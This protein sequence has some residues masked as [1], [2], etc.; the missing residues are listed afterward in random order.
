M[1]K[2][3]DRQFVFAPA[4]RERASLITM[5]S[6]SSGSGKTLSA[7]LLARGL[8]GGD[9]SKIG[10]IDTELGR[11]LHYAPARGEKPS[12]TKF[13]FQHVDL[14]PPFTPEFY[15]DAIL[16]ADE[17]G[18]PVIVVDSRS[19]EW[20]GEGGLKDIHDELVVIAVDRQRQVAEERKWRF[21]EVAASEKASIGAWRDPKGRH[22]KFVSRLLQVRAHLILCFRADEK[23]KMETQTDDNGRKRTVIIAAKDL[24]PAERWAPICEKRM[25]YEMTISLLLTPQEPGVPIPIKLQAQHMHAFEDGKPLTEATGRALAAWAAGGAI[26]AADAVARDFG[27]E[28]I[29]KAKEGSAAF[30]AWWL[31]LAPAAREPL[32]AR[33]AEFQKI[34]LD[35][36][37]A[38]D[39]FANTKPA[40]EIDK[41]ID[42]PS[43]PQGADLLADLTALGDARAAAGLDALTD[44][45][46]GLTPANSRLI[47]TE[48]RQAWLLAAGNMGVA[49]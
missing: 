2:R 48:Q 33:V 12:A 3:T 22:R 7:L 18:F 42:E 34:A 5:L 8:A 9:D 31:T 15:I 19:H 17:A 1:N 40:A 32:R 35:A 28:A 20:D 46:K 27:A 23:M 41:K 44:F 49:A 38:D 4:V 37:A 45:L 26:G 21:D 25:P 11:A 30:R 14:M 10:V 36:D 29:A 16:A 24:P 13:G 39:P 6:G 47:S 43:K